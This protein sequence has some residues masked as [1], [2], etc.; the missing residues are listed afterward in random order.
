MVCPYTQAELV[1][2]GLRGGWNC[3]VGIR[4]GKAVFPDRAAHL[5]AAITKCEVT[6]TV[7]DLGDAEAMRTQK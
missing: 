7:A 5:E 6:R 1:A 4:G 2:V 3:S